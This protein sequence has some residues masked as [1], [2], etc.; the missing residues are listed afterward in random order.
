MYKIRELTTIVSLVFFLNGLLVPYAVAQNSGKKDK[1]K[2]TDAAK[3]P[4]KKIRAE[5]GNCI[6]SKPGKEGN[7]QHIYFTI[8]DGKQV[9]LQYKQAPSLRRSVKVFEERRQ[10]TRDKEG[11]Y[12]EQL[13]RADKTV[14]AQRNSVQLLTAS[15]NQRDELIRRQT[16]Q[17]AGL[18]SARW[19]Y[20]VIGLSVGG[21]VVAGVMIGV[22]VWA[23][24]RN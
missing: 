17:I 19:K 24:N 1:S 2:T 21:A 18:K 12:K 10:L 23:G 16:V 7:A 11:W 6:R 8:Q 9:Y 3:A 15:L 14:T 20:L 4:K 13:Q 5:I 22:G